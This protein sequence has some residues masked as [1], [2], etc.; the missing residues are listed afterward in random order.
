MHKQDPKIGRNHPG[1]CGS[2]KNS[3]VIGFHRRLEFVSSK[4]P[5]GSFSRFRA[6]PCTTP[7]VSPSPELRPIRLRYTFY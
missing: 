2:A 1:A 6:Q 4:P 5:D 3:E 7:A